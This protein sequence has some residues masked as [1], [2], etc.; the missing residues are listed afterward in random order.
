MPTR[1]APLKEEIC[2]DVPQEALKE[3]VELCYMARSCDRLGLLEISKQ[4]NAIILRYNI[5]PSKV[6]AT[7]GW[8]ETR[9]RLLT[10]YVPKPAGARDYSEDEVFDLMK[11]YPRFLVACMQKYP[12]KD[13]AVNL[14]KV[15]TALNS[16]KLKAPELW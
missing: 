10:G 9:A 6:L 1:P 8:C 11:R 13:A 15:V 5:P 16:G 12:A 7:V 14:E 4:A 2:P 3:L